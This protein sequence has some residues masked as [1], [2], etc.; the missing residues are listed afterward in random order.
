[1][2]KNVGCIVPDQMYRFEI[3]FRGIP[4]DQVDTK[5]LRSYMKQC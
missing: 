5:L 4:T 1:M 3:C 2:K